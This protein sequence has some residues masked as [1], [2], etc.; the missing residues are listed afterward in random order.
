[1]YLQANG[2]ASIPD[3]LSFGRTYR[4]YVIFSTLARAQWLVARFVVIVIVA[5]T[6]HVAVSRTVINS[7]L[8]QKRAP[9]SVNVYFDM[10]SS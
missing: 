1:M 5:V 8:K 9:A 4:V 3:G 7:V 6:W 2:L 10:Y